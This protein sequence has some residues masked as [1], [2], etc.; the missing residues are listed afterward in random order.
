[1]T[2]NINFG[3]ILLFL[4]MEKIIRYV[5]GI[6]LKKTYFY[7][8]LE[9]VSE[10]LAYNL[11]ELEGTIF[12]GP[13]KMIAHSRTLMEVVLDKVL[14]HENLH[15]RAPENT[16]VHKIEKLVKHEL[17]SSTQ[18]LAFEEI[19]LLGNKASHEIRKF[20]FSEALK[21][22]ENIH[23]VMKWFVELYVS[24]KID[25]PTYEDPMIDQEYPYE[26]DEIHVRLEK[27]E[28][29]LKKSM[30]FERPKEEKEKVQET[31][32]KVQMKEKLTS[33]HLDE[34]PGV[35]TVRT[36]TFKGE[37]IHI[38]H[39]LRDAFLLPQ[40]F[41]RSERFLLRLNEAQE[42]RIMSE[43]PTSLDNLHERIVRFN[44]SHVEQFVEELKVFITEE[45]RRRLLLQKRPG[46]L[47]L[48][49]EGQ[50]IVV[51]D[52]LGNIAITKE[53]FPGSPSLIEQLHSDGMQIVK[54]LPK[55]FIII[56]KYKGIGKGRVTNFFKQIKAMQ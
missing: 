18:K 34:A 33:L 32:Q 7:Q 14:I 29:L 21:T 4:N 35:T 2:F 43:L 55:E 12:T 13:R 17:I 9:P 15:V 39:F 36:L 5:G 49:Y 45:K 28:Q 48:F 31:V 56:G 40:R 44:M 51:T 27:F 1:M 3:L 24:Y 53:T 26:L 38:P 8:F 11:Q 54:D 52:K 22:W 23:V 19:R 30:E 10:E 50:Q 20:R 42:A 47:F 37:E 25:V 41:E 46:D 6:I 16:L